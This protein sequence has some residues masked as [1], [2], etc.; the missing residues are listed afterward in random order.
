MDSDASDNVAKDSRLTAA[1]AIFAGED[2]SV[3]R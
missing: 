2:K 1:I 3:A